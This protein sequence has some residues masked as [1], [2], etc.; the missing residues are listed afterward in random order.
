MKELK[1]LQDINTQERLRGVL[2][3]QMEK[4]KELNDALKSRELILEQGLP[5]R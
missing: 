1:E 3:K 2:I 4:A 5:M